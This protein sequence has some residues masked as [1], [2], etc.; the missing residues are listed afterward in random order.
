MTHKWQKNWK[1]IKVYWAQCSRIQLC[2][3][4]ST[5]RAFSETQMTLTARNNGHLLEL[6]ALTQE[7]KSILSQKL[8]KCLKTTGVTLCPLCSVISSLTLGMTDYIYI[9]VSHRI[10]F[11]ARWVDFWSSVKTIWLKNWYKWPFRQ[12]GLPWWFS[13]GGNTGQEKKE[14]RRKSQG[15]YI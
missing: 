15:T 3:N 11:L 4:A 7:E 8:G 13:C 9:H 2:R 1:I 12:R 14:N 10:L 5:K 6:K